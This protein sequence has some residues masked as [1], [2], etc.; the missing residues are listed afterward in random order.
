MI[1][2]KIKNLIPEQIEA[3][4][5]LGQEYSDGDRINDFD[6]RICSDRQY[7]KIC[8]W[9]VSVENLL[10]SLF[11]DSTNVFSKH[12]ALHIKNINE[13]RPYYAYKYVSNIIEVLKSLSDAI[14]KGLLVNLADQSQ[15]SAFD[16]FLQHA[17]AYAKDKRHME[18]GVIAGVVFEDTI[19]KLCAKYS[20]KVQSDK[21]EQ[22]INLLKSEGI[23][24]GTKSKR[25]KSAAD[26]RGNAAHAKWDAYDILD[27]R[28]AISI[29][30][31]LIA[32]HLENN[33]A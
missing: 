16:D 7:A 18:A 17:E 9:I 8:G 15:A 27:V 31:E 1:E 24:S 33:N 32:E 23:I 29:T 3:L 13:Q 11:V 2:R 14:V 26:V 4:I 20:L 28:E 21:L 5:V 12:V 6:E 22:H 25:C 30:R 19:K 10:E